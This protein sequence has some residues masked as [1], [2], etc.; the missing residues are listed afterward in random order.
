MCPARDGTAVHGYLVLP[1]GRPARDLPVIVYPHGGPHWRDVWEMGRFREIQLL[2]NRGYAVL[3][4]NFRGST[5]Y[6]KSYLTAGF[7]QNGLAVQNDLT[8][9]VRHLISEGIADPSRIAIIGGSYGGY[10]VLAGLAFTPELYACG[11]SLF[12]VSSF[13][14]FLEA[15]AQWTDMS[16]HYER[17]GHPIRDRELLT[18]TSPLLHVENIRVPILIAQGGRDPI[19]N[20]EESDQMVAALREQNVP[21][22]YIYHAEEGHGYFSRH[23]NWLDLWRAIEAFLAEHLDATA[24][25]TAF[26]G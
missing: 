24:S 20:P 19:V 17:I 10:A 22:E 8:D 25:K 13:F 4:V 23:D 16:V 18:R 3:Q 15:L 2:A 11:V 21:V 5:G 7:K 14:T 12:G 6:G 9:G 1:P 26:G